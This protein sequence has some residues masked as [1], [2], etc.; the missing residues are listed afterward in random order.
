MEKLTLKE[1]QIYDYICETIKREGFSPSVRDIQNALGIK[2][3]STVHTYI[4]RLND[5]G[6]I[7]KKHGKSRVFSLSILRCLE[8]ATCKT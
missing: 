5:K 7:A 2:S 6:L 4:E 1:K 3:T 8:I